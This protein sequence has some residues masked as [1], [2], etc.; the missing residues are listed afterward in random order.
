M[1][2]QPLHH[3]LVPFLRRPV[4]RTRAIGPAQA[5][6]SPPLEQQVDEF[7]MTTVGGRDQLGLI[8]LGM[9]RL[10]GPTASTKTAPPWRAA[11]DGMASLT[12]LLRPFLIVLDA[13]T[14]CI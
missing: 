10:G 1:G 12:G 3:G 5:R 14:P 4:Q 13:H 6:I 8:I 11:H 2:K 9:G 7:S